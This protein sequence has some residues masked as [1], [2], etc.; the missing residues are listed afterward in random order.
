MFHREP[1]VSRWNTPAMRR[2]AECRQSRV[3]ALSRCGHRADHNPPPLARAEGE[4]ARGPFVSHRQETCETARACVPFSR[5]RSPRTCISARRRASEGMTRGEPLNERHT[6][7]RD[8]TQECADCWTRGGG[9]CR[10][11][12]GRWIPGRLGRERIDRRAG[13]P[14]DAEQ[15]RMGLPAWGAVQGRDVQP[16][17]GALRL[18]RTVAD[19]PEGA[20]VPFRSCLGYFV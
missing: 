17:V 4:G 16:S 13:R 5:V 7:G 1:L 11:R 15:P 14:V 20:D 8:V 6:G 10:L 2:D 9:L 12:D 18:R 3:F 19:G